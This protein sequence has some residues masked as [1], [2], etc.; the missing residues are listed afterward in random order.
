MRVKGSLLGKIL[1]IFSVNII[2]TFVEILDSLLCIFS[3][4]T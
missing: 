3:I 1:L 2:H 4:R